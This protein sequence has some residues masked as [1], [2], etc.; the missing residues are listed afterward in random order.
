MLAI[1]AAL[2]TIAAYLVTSTYV[3]LAGPPGILLALALRR[4]MILYWLG[5]HGVRLALFVAGLR[6]VAHGVEHVA[7]G[8]PAIYCVNHSSN[9][10]PP[11]VFTLLRPLFPRLQIIYKS[12]LRKLPVLGRVFEVA[13]FVPIDRRDR[14]QSDRAIAQAARQI[15]EGNSFLVFPEG[16]RSV[17]G[18]LLPFKKGAFILALEARAP[19]VPVAIVGAAAAMRR[20]S[21]FIWPATMHVRFG[22]AIPTAG[23]GWEDRDALMHQVRER[24]GALMAE[25]AS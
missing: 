20:G 24:I 17:T 13:G 19:I 10:E 2:R 23:L 8:R 25:G 12:E 6:V 16:T 15:A 21:P 18:E 1:T 5:V 11:A 14:A 7:P 9:L 22:A 4:P 3:L